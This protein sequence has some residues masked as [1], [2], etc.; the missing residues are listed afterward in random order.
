DRMEI[1]IVSDGSTDGTDDIL[2]EFTDPALMI[3]RC[4]EHRGKAAALNMGIER[5]TGEILIFCDIRPRIGSNALKLLLSNFADPHVG[6]VAGE[7]I[8]LEDGHD[9]GAKAVGGFYWRY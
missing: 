1:V 2:N 9:A 7:L 6:C 4:S 5:S 3:V 8:L